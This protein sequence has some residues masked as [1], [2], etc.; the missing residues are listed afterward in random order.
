MPRIF[1]PTASTGFHPVVAPAARGHHACF[2]QFALAVPHRARRPSEP[3]NPRPPYDLPEYSAPNPN[4]F[5]VTGLGGRRRP[6]AAGD[7]NADSKVVEK[8]APGMRSPSLSPSLPPGAILSPAGPV[9]FERRAQ[10]VLWLAASGPR[11]T[12]YLAPSVRARSASV[13]PREHRDDG[14]RALSV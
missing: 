6:I 14:C 8:L 1:F 2:G 4:S 13:A 5:P 10:C 7:E 3:C 9:P 12:R 11:S